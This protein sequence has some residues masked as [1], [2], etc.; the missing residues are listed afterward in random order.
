VRALIELG[1]EVQLVG[2]PGVEGLSSRRAEKTV[3]GERFGFNTIWRL[4]SR[5]A[6]EPVFEALEIAYN[7]YSVPR[8]LAHVRRSSSYLIYDRLSL[9]HLAPLIASTVYGIPLVSEVN[10]SAVIH[11]SRPLLFQRVARAMERVVL[12]RSS[13]V[14]TVSGRFQELL[15]DAHDVRRDDVLVTP[16]AVDPTRF[17]Q[18]E[19]APKELRRR[20]GLEGRVVVGVIGGFVAWH[21]LDHL[22]HSLRDLLIDRDDRRIL[23]VGD[24]PVRTDV[25]QLVSRLKLDGRVQFTGFVPAHEIPSYIACMDVCLMPDSNEHGSP[26]KIFEYMAAGKPIAAPR[27]GPIE[28]VIEDE[29]NGLLFRPRDREQLRQSV[30]RLLQD[31]E[32]RSRLGQAGRERVLDRH[33][34]LHNAR[35]VLANLN[36]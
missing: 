18:T 13:L 7:L 1:H 22:I 23:L 14:V 26:I 33:T 6:P 16:N 5:G 19:K 27:Y 15:S 4:I 2:P 11:R 21:G 30:S 28:E 17:A 25:E 32:L 8:L 9:F 12:R 10:D 29:V 20:L 3:T 24:G 34:W 36:C 35:R 31:G